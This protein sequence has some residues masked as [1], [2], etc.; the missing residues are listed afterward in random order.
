MFFQLFIFATVAASVLSYGVYY[1][2]PPHLQ[3]GI[4]NNLRVHGNM[5][6]SFNKNLHYTY[7][8]ASRYCQHYGGNLATIRD[9]STQTFL[10]TTMHSG[11]GYGGEVW[12]GL[13]DRRS[14]GS[15]EWS[16]GTAIT[17]QRWAPGQPYNVLGLG[18]SEEDCV[19]MDM[20]EGGLWHDNVCNH[21]LFLSYKKAFICEYRK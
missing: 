19:F 2:C 12:I 15:F 20:G 21:L 7:N 13:S 4:S 11:L 14:E 3:E 5:C 8:D 17:Y 18:D 10:Y 1:K 16:D 6:Y 9:Q